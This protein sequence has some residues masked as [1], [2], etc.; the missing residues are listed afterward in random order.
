MDLFAGSFS[1]GLH[2]LR[3]AEVRAVA[4]WLQAVLFVGAHRQA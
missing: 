2:P 4:F 3:F 1:S